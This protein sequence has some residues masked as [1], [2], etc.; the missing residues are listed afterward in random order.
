MI[1]CL[2]YLKIVNKDHN[3]TS[4]I[5]TDEIM[6]MRPKQSSNKKYLKLN[7]NHLLNI[8]LLMRRVELSTI[9]YNV[10]VYIELEGI[11]KIPAENIS[12]RFLEWSI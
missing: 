8:P 2:H 11:G 7:I 12:S 4:F 10:R 9:F 6:Q 5:V 3:Y 1:Q